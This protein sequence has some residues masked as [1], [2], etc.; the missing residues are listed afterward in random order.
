MAKA[1][2]VIVSKCSQCPRFL[3]HFLGLR[4]NCWRGIGYYVPL[5]DPENIPEDCPLDDASGDAYTGVG[6]RSKSY[7]SGAYIYIQIEKIINNVIDSKIKQ[8][9]ERCLDDSW[10]YIDD[11]KEAKEKLLNEIKAILV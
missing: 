10:G 4:Q 7:V 3:D 6:T 2:V 9:D 8:I 11:I 5:D 1:C